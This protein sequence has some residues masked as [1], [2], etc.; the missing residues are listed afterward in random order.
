[1]R[2]ALLL[3][4][5]LVT[6]CHFSQI[7][8]PNDVAE[9]SKLD[10]KAL[11][12]RVS[13][14]RRT[15]D[16]YQRQGRIDQSESTVLL[17]NYVEDQ[18]EGVETAQIPSQQAWRFGDVYRQAENWEKTRELYTIAVTNAKSEDR[19]VNDTLRLAEATA[20][21]GDVPAGIDM[22][23]S[24]FDT[25]PGD[26]GPI[27]MATLYEF[28]PACLNQGFD[29]ELARVLED[30]VGEHMKTIVDPKTDEGLAFLDVRPVHINRAYGLI[31]R[32]YQSAGEYEEARNAARRSAT[33]LARFS[34]A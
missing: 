26:K 10:G 25:D 3:P 16:I 32:L 30:A 1:M 31:I 2:I 4:L 6:G 12:E 11:Q 15:L 34:E 7:P 27:L 14:V 13:L 8:D 5:V 28:V 18:L 29:D 9:I 19:R 23:R 33:L 24:T 20:Q 17:A 22:V 21:L